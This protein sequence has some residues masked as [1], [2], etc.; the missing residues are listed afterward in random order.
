MSSY[1][2][3]R[4]KESLGSPVNMEQRVNW[5]SGCKV[6]ANE[7]SWLSHRTKRWSSEHRGI[8]VMPKAC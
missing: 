1:S 4:K 2:L 3:E 5:G 6:W 8:I 7:G